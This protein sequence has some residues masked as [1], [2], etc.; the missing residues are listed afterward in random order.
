MLNAFKTNKQ[1][2]NASAR[3]VDGKLIL[4]LPD[5]QTPVVWQMDITQTKSSA[6]EARHNEETGTYTLTLKTPRGETVDIAPFDNREFAVEGLMAASHALEN[7][8][9]QIRNETAAA[10]DQ[11]IYAAPPGNKK[12]NTKKI[13]LAIITVF[14]LLFLFNIWGSQL[15]RT[16]SSVATGTSA[17]AD[18]NPRESS[19]VAISADD[20][21]NAQ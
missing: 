11:T 7:A 13:F 1:T 14:A 17:S 9:G 2:S 12:S 8:Y 6:L 4:S 10:N 5:A 16:P 21:L 3:V 18:T 20:F 15:P 19:G